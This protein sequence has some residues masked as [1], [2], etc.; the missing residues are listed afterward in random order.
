[1][2][3]INN[4]FSFFPAGIFH[5]RDFWRKNPC[6]DFF[7]LLFKGLK[8][9]LGSLFQPVWHIWVCFKYILTFL[10]SPW[11]K[12]PAE[13]FPRRNFSPQGFF[14]M[15]I[16]SAQ[17][18]FLVDFIQ[19]QSIFSAFI[20]IYIVYGMDPAQLLHVVVKQ[21]GKLYIRFTWSQTQRQFFTL[22]CPYT[23]IHSKAAPVR[24][25]CLF[26]LFNHFAKSLDPDQAL[27]LR[28]RLQDQD[29]SCLI[30]WCFFF[31]DFAWAL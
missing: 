20:H 1:M 19:W 17:Y 8:S 2:S 27:H 12:I 25:T 26:Y 4:N 5:H 22:C 11:G 14:P 9:S 23:C 24:A 3:T 29:P 13:I 16:F 15:G 21:A 30:L 28:Y 31:S 10:F 6:G 18:S 7:K